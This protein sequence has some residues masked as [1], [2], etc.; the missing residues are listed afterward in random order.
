MEKGIEGNNTGSPVLEQQPAANQV[1]ERLA[2]L[3]NALG[4]NN[5]IKEYIEKNSAPQSEPQNPTIQTIKT[6]SGLSA[7]ITP[8]NQSG[9][10]AGDEK[11]S[12]QGNQQGSNEQLES[13]KEEN[14]SGD[15]I[16]LEHS[17]F[18]GK[19]TFGKDT[20]KGGEGNEPDLDLKSVDGL[21]SL[22]KSKLGVESVDKIP[23]KLESLVSGQQKLSELESQM[24]NVT[25]LFNEMD[26]QLYQAIVAWQNGEDW[27]ASVRDS[28]IDFTK[29]AKSYDAKT[30]VNSMLPGKISDTQWEEYQQEDCD[31][32]VKSLVD[33]AIESATDRFTSKAE[34]IKAKSS[35][36]VAKSAEKKQKFE[37][38]IETSMKFLASKYPNADQTYLSGV[39]DEF[40]T[41]KVWSVFM[42]E[43]GSLREDAMLR[44]VMAKDGDNLLQQTIKKIENAKTTIVHQGILDHVAEIPSGQNG[45]SGASKGRT[46]LRPEVEE[47]LAFI[48]G[49]KITKKTFG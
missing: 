5:P 35:E 39:A 33:F 6:D 34:S 46:E 24:S 16:A 2:G 20:E 11:T 37:S 36:M 17:L 31:P 21:T 32:A 12:S 9:A 48:N 23:E 29:D 13:K 40:K 3:S 27:K 49:T 44:Y 22:F 10:V 4:G 41:G 19:L 15:E 30:L 14:A 28:Q 1:A 26:P 43:D 47:K 38:S 7:N 25:A 42:N 8:D 18:G 45:S